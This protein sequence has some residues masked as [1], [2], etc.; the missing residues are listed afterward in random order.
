MSI[1]RKTQTYLSSATWFWSRGFPSRL[2]PVG[3]SLVRFLVVDV[4]RA[5]HGHDGAVFLTDDQG[6]DAGDFWIEKNID[7]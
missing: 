1:T 2:L 3:D 4:V 7:I 5:I 6:R